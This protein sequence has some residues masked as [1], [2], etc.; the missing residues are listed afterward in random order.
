MI[1][2]EVVS[3]FGVPGALRTPGPRFRK[4]RKSPS[5]KRR[6]GEGDGFS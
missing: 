1:A 5:N 4:V 3:V 2:K 6:K